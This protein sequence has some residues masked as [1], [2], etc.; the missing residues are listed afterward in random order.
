MISARAAARVLAALAA[1]TAGDGAKYAAR[2]VW[3][4]AIIDAV[5]VAIM[6][7]GVLTFALAATAKHTDNVT[8]LQFRQAIEAEAA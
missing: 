5:F 4:A 3:D 2:G 8:E 1:L 7:G 6:L